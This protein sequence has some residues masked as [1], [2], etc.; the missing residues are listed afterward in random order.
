MQG[1][2]TCA[3]PPQCLANPLTPSL[4]YNSFPMVWRL[5]AGGGF[6]LALLYWL[7][8]VGEGTY[9]GPR[10]VRLIYRLGARHYDRVRGFPSPADQQVLLPLLKAATAGHAN[11]QLLDVATGTG[12][13]PLLLARNGVAAQIQGLDLTPAMLAQA[14]TTQLSDCP[15]ARIGWYVG[16]AGALPWP[17]KQFDVVTCLEALEFFPHPRR[18]ISE[19]CRVLRPGGTLFVSKFPDGWARA[20]PGK[21]FTR[22]A[23]VRYLQ[24]CGMKNVQC[25]EWQPGHYELVQ[26]IKQGSNL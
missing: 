9:L 4:C 2:P 26:S 25:M 24:K 13:V 5:L 11:P 14:Q 16:E 21:A 12:R 1:A 8:V 7:F 18:A 22:Q 23:M 3:P 19:M 17:A 20:L 6:G 15:A 10:V